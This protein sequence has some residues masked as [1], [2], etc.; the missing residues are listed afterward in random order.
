MPMVTKG[1]RKYIPAV[2]WTWIIIFSLTVCTGS[3]AQDDRGIKRINTRRVALVIGNGNYTTS[4]LRNPANDADDMEKVLK[5][6]K[7]TVIKGTNLNKREMLNYLSRFSKALRRADVGLFFFGGHG[8]QFNNRNYLIPVGCT[9]ADE[10]DVEFESLDAG[11]VIKKMAAAGSRLNIV[12][13]DACRNNPFHRSFR[14][15]SQGLARMDAPKGTIIAYA[16]SPGSVA[17][18]GTGRNGTY[19]R[20]LLSAFPVPGLNIQDIFNQAGMGVMAE[21]GD[22]QIPWTS[23]TPIPRYFL[24]GGPG[25]GNR[26]PFKEGSIT[27]KPTP[28]DSR[29]RILNIPPKYRDGIQLEPGRYHIEVSA[30]GYTRH[31]EWISLEAEQN[32]VL[33]IDLVEESVPETVLRPSPGDTWT[34]PVTGMV[35]VRVREGCF[36]MG[37]TQS[38]KDYLI[39]EYGQENYDKYYTDEHPRHQVCLDGFW[40]AR[41]EVTRDQFALFIR[42]TGYRTDA[43]KKGKA[44]IYNKETDWTWK[45]KSGHNWKNPGYS[46]SGTHPAAT[47]SWND[48]KAFIKWLSK[49]SDQTFALP[50]EA[51]WEYAARGGITDMRFWGREDK[52]ACTYANIADKGS[53]WSNAFPCSDGYK[54][55]APTGSFRSNPFGLYDMLGNL[56]E[57]CE[58]VYDKKAYSKHAGKNPVITSGASSR[59]LRGGGWGNDPRVVRAA[60]RYWGVPGSA[61][62]SVGFRVCAP[63]VR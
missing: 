57:W 2:C 26:T 51:Q 31:R 42:E 6:L 44:W 10:T 59:V 60:N 58:D 19:T 45:E 16:T 8:I 39:K 50:T 20:H 56:W 36:Q 49:K 22:K 9:V 25:D 34:E 12:I 28:P 4:P 27:V 7:F 47:V 55:T 38:E 32:L 37:Q 30:S 21:T 54:F 33:N 63:R 11:R 46:Q 24:A 48:A 3:A 40:M 18:D 53:N 43:D 5:T 13:L 52:N 14:S 17:L 29:V 1:N 41:K 62:S 23:N 15:A 35:F 61:F